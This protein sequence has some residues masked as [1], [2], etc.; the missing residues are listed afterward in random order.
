L[1]Q[2][3]TR[4][5][6]R[7]ALIAF[8]IGVAACCAWILSLPVF[9]SED[10]PVH[11]YYATV[12]MKL[13]S[14][15]HGPLTVAFRIRHLL[16]P[17][18]LYYYLLI[19]LMQVFPAVLVEQIAA[20]IIVVVMAFGFRFL[21]MAAGPNGRWTSFLVLPLLLNWP[22]FM[23]FENYCLSIGLTFWAMGVWFG[24]PR[25][26]RG[27][28]LLLV[29]A[30]VLT[31]PV[32]LLL[33]TPLC[34][35]DLAG[36]WFLQTSS[37]WRFDLATLICACASMS[38]VLLFTQANKVKQNLLLHIHPLLSLKQYAA[39]Y[40]L[41][42]FA[43]MSAATLL[44]T[45]LLIAIFLT[46][47]LLAARSFF[48][49]KQERRW[50][51]ADA[52]FLATVGLLIVL[53]FVPDTMN[54]GFY[55]NNRLLIFAWCGA[56]A[57]ASG[58]AVLGSP[59]RVLLPSLG[60]AALIVTLIVA[61]VRIAPEARRAAVAETAP[62]A[63]MG[64][65]AILMPATSY[66][67]DPALRFRP[68]EWSAAR[69]F[70]RADDVMLDAPFLDMATMPIDTRQPQF[71]GTVV[72]GATND[73]DDLVKRAKHDPQW[74]RILFIG[75]DLVLFRDAFHRSSPLEMQQHLHQNGKPQMRCV[76]QDWLYFCR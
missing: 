54:G 1:N 8:A 32:P 20:C 18:S 59:L 23:G 11:L 19:L 12:M 30:I 69:Y 10:G 2:T 44:Y 42:L 48:R 72:P 51:A 70:R 57:A 63:E 14:G 43:R 64:E 74:A 7:G 52:L 46:S 26:R 5:R 17:Y 71:Q 75:A 31:H 6:Q 36:R 27:I 67:A 21:C 25:Y 60:Y 13:L 22:I 56:I 66:E 28:F 61:Q 40:G 58:G 53:P 68:L 39:L 38:Y 50:H 49:R 33:L 34:A 24:R 29:A 55:F 45:A 9:P 3:S 47:L 76:Q 35:I 62:I 15:A 41:G 73:L 65:S 37:D 4:L 16:P